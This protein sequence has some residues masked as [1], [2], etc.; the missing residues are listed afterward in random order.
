MFFFFFSPHFGFVPVCLRRGESRG[1]RVK[2]FPEKGHYDSGGQRTA[3]PLC[4][5]RMIR[6][7][8]LLFKCVRNVGYKK[9]KHVGI[10]EFPSRCLVCGSHINWFSSR[11]LCVFSFF[12][13]TPCW[14]WNSRWALRWGG[15]RGSGGKVLQRP[16]AA[17]KMDAGTA[18]AEAAILVSVREQRGTVRRF[19]SSRY[20]HLNV[21][22][23]PHC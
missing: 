13:R 14:T 15:G 8:L 16:S 12:F 10:L 23:K 2:M 11:R 20:V 6:L 5:R 4:D 7:L 22:L 9:K 18:G 1:Q 17:V 19:S 3:A 21:Y